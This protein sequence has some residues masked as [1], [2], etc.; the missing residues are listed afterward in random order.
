MIDIE[1]AWGDFCGGNYNELDNIPN[2]ENIENI[3][4]RKNNI[5][6]CT[7][8]YIST[9]TKMFYLNCNI[10]LDELFW[11]IQVMPYYKQQEG[12]IKKQM[13]FSCNNNQELDT[14]ISKLAEYKNIMTDMQII[15]QINNTSG[16]TKFKD[17]RKLTI[18][19][20]KKD[21]IS[22]RKKKKGAFI[23]CFILILRVL[24]NSAYK[25]IHIKVFNTGKIEIPGIQYDIYID[26]IMD[27]LIHILNKY[28]NKI[29]HYLKDKTE[30][31]LINSNFSCGFYINRNKLYE[32]L[33]N[34]YNI[35]CSY[36]PC[37]YPGIQ[38]AFY[39][40]SDIIDI[41]LQDGKQKQNKN[42]VRISFMIFRT[43][44]ILIVGKCDENIL[45]VVYKYIRNILIKEK[46]SIFDGINID[47]KKK[48]K[49]T[50]KYVKKI[51]NIIEN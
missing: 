5:D 49:K 16:R 9:K 29:T 24:I 26:L 3:E 17:V 36:D 7:D 13:K 46:S 51:V 42:I 38:C 44:S 6:K 1:T 47:I 40:D 34:K 35:N 41:E 39:Y 45:Q 28:N 18:G 50:T 27:L 22:Y 43:G 32:L 23:N 2:I 4:N 31:I 12:I 14:V 30:T 33:N 37:S 21:I 19:L 11:K 25:E 10:E 8:L 20:S 15:K 48:I